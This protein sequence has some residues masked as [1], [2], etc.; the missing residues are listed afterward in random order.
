[1]FAVPLFVISTDT[2]SELPKLQEATGADTAS[3]LASRADLYLLQPK[4]MFGLFA[5]VPVKAVFE[6]TPVASARRYRAEVNDVVVYLV[7]A[8]P[9]ETQLVLLK[10]TSTTRFDVPL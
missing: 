2:L 6:H 3:R 7:D 10:Q 8:F 4:I 1:M 9:F 5:L